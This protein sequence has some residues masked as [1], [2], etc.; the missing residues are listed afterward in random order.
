MWEGGAMRCVPESGRACGGCHRH[1]NR[2][3]RGSKSALLRTLSMPRSWMS[4]SASLF[5]CEPCCFCFAVPD[6][7]CL[8]NRRPVLTLRVVSSSSRRLLVGSIFGSSFARLAKASRS[9][10]EPLGVD[11][12]D[13]LDTAAAPGCAALPGG[14]GC[15]G[16]T[17]CCCSCCCCCCCCSCCCC[18]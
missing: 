7:V 16:C 13:V 3:I 6:R 5:F 18:S 8:S 12:A 2:R 10:K 4:N 11:G 1:R 9:S 17:C 14:A 15:R